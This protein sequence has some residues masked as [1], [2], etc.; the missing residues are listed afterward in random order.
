M[1]LK[2]GPSPPQSPLSQLSRRMPLTLSVP[3]VV[4]ALASVRAVVSSVPSP[5]ARYSS[6]NPASGTPW[7]YVHTGAPLLRQVLRL[8]P[9]L[10]RD[11]E[12]IIPVPR[13]QVHSARA[14]DRYTV[15]PATRLCNAAVT[16]R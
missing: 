5:V 16:W 6:T 9:S 15:S 10:T 4:D 11:E 14:R 1:P 8:M 12:L 7:L 3:V 13:N 2:D